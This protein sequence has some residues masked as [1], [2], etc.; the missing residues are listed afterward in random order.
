MEQREIAKLISHLHDLDITKEFEDEIAVLEN[1]FK[2][3]GNERAKDLFRDEYNRL[4][5]KIQ[6]ENELKKL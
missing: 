4:A 2:N 6:K 5:E 1:D 3:A